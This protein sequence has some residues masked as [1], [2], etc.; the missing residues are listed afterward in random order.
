MPDSQVPLHEQQIAYLEKKRRMYLPLVGGWPPNLQDQALLAEVRAHLVEDIQHSA[1]FV[2]EHPS[3]LRGM[4]LHG[5]L[6]RMGHNVDVPGAAQESAGV[7]RSVLAANPHSCPAALSLASLYVTLHPSLMA[8]AEQYFRIALDLS[9][10]AP[11]PL[12]FQGLGFACLHQQKTAQA[13][14]YFRKYLGLVPADERI[15][16]VVGKLSAGVTPTPVF[17]PLGE[18]ASG[19]SEVK[20]TEKPWW[21]FW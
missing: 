8:E 19:G 15:S 12:I 2:R 11:D 21:R 7:L 5:D 17:V 6:L 20:R 18:R 10:E 1:S 3:N 9:A 4:E 16:E 13:L 14:E